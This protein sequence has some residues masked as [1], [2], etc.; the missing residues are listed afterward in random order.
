MSQ[1]QAEST[2]PGNADTQAKAAKPD[3]NSLPPETL[4][5]A[6]KIF[7]A[8]RSGD[9]NL[10]LSAV[11]A[12]LPSNLTNAKG[13]LSHCAV[14]KGLIVFNCGHDFRRQHTPNAVGLCGAY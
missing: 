14:L 13:I 4:E 10:V 9:S 3:A 8:A 7:D 6:Q 5:F 1:Y 12:G 2:A 11:D